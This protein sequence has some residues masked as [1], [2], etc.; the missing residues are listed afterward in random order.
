[1]LYNLNYVLVWIQL[2]TAF[3]FCNNVYCWDPRARWSWGNAR[4]KRKFSLYAPFHLIQTRVKHCSWIP[5]N[6]YAPFHSKSWN[7]KRTSLLRVLFM[8]L[9]CAVHRTR[10][11][12]NQIIKTVR[13]SIQTA[14]SILF[15]F[16]L[17]LST[18]NGKMLSIPFNALSE[19][20][21]MSFTYPP[22]T[23]L[24]KQST[25]VDESK[26]IMQNQKKRSP[27][28]NKSSSS[29]SLRLGHP[30]HHC[31][32][33]HSRVSCLPWGF[34]NLWF[35]VFN[36]LCVV[37][38]FNVYVWFSVVFSMSLVCGFIDPSCNT[39]VSLTT[40]VVFG[41]MWVYFTFFMWACLTNYDMHPN[42]LF[43]CLNEYRRKL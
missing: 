6:L 42:C 31:G 18:T 38:V 33:L 41:Y 14:I 25:P 35:F 1:M 29:P 4:L 43:K 15:N 7:N 3:T 2:N 10:S 5:F 40:F 20:S 23:K 36:R 11:L 9:E 12:E 13:S 17:F 27:L 16:L 8:A 32:S 34:I 30:C 24:S 39:I 28:F 37:F 19:S 21:S 22:T 26:P